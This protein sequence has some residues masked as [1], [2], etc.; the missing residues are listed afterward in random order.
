MR[1]YRFGPDPE[2]RER[3]LDN[4]QMQVADKDFAA[5]MRLHVEA[6]P[7]LCSQR[8]VVTDLGPL[9]PGKDTSARHLALIQGQNVQHFLVR[10]GQPVEQATVERGQVVPTEA[11]ETSEL[12]AGARIEVRRYEGRQLYVDG[13]PVGDPFR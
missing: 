10:R 7:W 3:Q 8:C 1:P 4:L 5:Q 2:R 9:E 13:Q 12:G 11:A 6:N